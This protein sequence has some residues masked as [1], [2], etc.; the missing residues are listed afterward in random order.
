[1]L[2]MNKNKFGEWLGIGTNIAVVAGIVALAFE[3]SQ[4]TKQ[5]RA[6]ASYNLLQNRLEAR[7]EIVNN[8]EISEFW[9]RIESGD[10]ITPADTMRIQASAEAAL[11]KWHWEFSQYVDGNLS[12][13]ELPLNAYRLAYR[14][15][16][17]VWLSGI[18]EAWLSLKDQL[19]PDFVAWMEANVTNQ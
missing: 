2:S 19:R 1:M 11:L 10:S 9:T 12:L 3:V 18:P 5:L 13:T 4:N 16:Y 15:E 17:G 8:P 7:S 14:G 6:Q